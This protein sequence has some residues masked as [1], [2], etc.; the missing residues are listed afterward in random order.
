M[1]TSFNTGRKDSGVWPSSSTVG[2]RSSVG[3]READ[4][5]VIRV[6]EVE[7]GRQI[8]RHRPAPWRDIALHDSETLL[9]ELNDRRV[10]EDL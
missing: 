7:D 10:I 9:D 1:I 8:A 6:G 3:G 5:S 4:G 2:G